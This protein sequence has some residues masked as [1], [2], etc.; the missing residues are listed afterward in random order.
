M[1]VSA[2]T[3]TVLAIGAG[4]LASSKGGPTMAAEPRPGTYRNPIID[5]PGA[6]DPAVI[7]YRGVYYL[8]PTLDGEGYD[9]WTSR[10]LVRWE[11]HGKVFT[12]A[13]R[14]VWAPDVFHHARGDGR[15]YL[16]YTVD[17]R[18]RNKAIGVA[19]ADGPLGPFHDVKTL[20]APAID[21]HMFRD[22]DG[23]LYLYY[24]CLAQG[25]R[26]MV[27]R[28]A[29]PLTPVGEPVE[30]IRPTEPWEKHKYPVTE[31][32]WMLK[33]RGIY[34]LMYSGSHAAGPDYAIGYATARSPMGPFTKHPGNPIAQ[35]GG[36]VLGPGHHSVVAAP[37]GRLW[38]VYHQK[39]SDRV[40]WDRFLAI[41]PLWFDRHGVIHTRLSRGTDQPAP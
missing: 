11:K 15:F 12:D 20:R 22:D 17:D 38:M 31:G 34:Y 39:A 2:V 21:A 27:W 10:D 29:D 23:S 6:A 30:V 13:R 28:M 41:D 35:R 40:G 33:R 8:Y 14:G 16:Y 26:I 32:P 7:R 24:T 5:A 4:L 36:D 18:Q 9:A 1:R 25:F 37:N 3:L 19:V